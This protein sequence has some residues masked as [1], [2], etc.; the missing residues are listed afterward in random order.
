[1]DDVW[2]VKKTLEILGFLEFYARCDILKNSIY[3]ENAAKILTGLMKIKACVTYSEFFH[4]GLCAGHGL[5]V[6]VVTHVLTMDESTIVYFVIDK[7]PLSWKD[8]KRNI[9][10]KNE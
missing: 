4:L 9:K 8:A 3:R 6:W 2:T 1:M 5:Q 10:P 7:L